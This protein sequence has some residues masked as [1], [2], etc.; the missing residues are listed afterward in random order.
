VGLAIVAAVNAHAL[1]VLE[2]DRVLERVA[3]RATSEAGAARTRALAPRTDREWIAAELRR[4]ATARL[5][6]EEHEWSPPAIPQ[7][8]EPLRRLRAAGS[9]WSGL[10]LL[11]GA[12]LLRSSR[13]T[14]EAF[15]RARVA[16]ADI[17]ALDELHDRLIVAQ[18]PEAAIERAVDSDGTLRDDASPALRR[19]RRFRNC[20]HNSLCSFGA[21]QFIFL[22][23]TGGV[24]FSSVWN[25]K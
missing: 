15:G 22:G 10:D 4:V 17:S 2:F 8:E 23:S 3:E 6:R 20:V 24:L 7:L 14:R 19:L 11:G 5:L 13:E 12:T 18:G 1:R 16:D 21:T 9:V 25:P